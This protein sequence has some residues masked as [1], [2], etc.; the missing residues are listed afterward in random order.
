MDDE[1]G[2]NDGGIRICDRADR[3]DEM[4]VDDE[5]DEDDEEEE[6]QPDL[7]A[8]ARYPDDPL[9]CTLYNCLPIQIRTTMILVLTMT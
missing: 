4:A 1:G 2:G 8:L 6:E 5:E 9:E 7:E 3:D